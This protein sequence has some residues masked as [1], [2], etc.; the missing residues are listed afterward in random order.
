MAAAPP[1]IPLI[2]E[3]DLLAFQL[4]HFA[5]DTRPQAWF[6]DPETALHY[7]HPL[8]NDDDDDGLGFYDD[9]AKRTLT[10][11]QIAMFRHSE[12]QQVL[13]ERR[14]R[15]EEQE[16]QDRDRAPDEAGAWDAPACVPGPRASSLEADL[17]GFAHPLPAGGPATD[18]QESRPKRRDSDS[19]LE[20]DLVGL[21]GSPSR[22][23]TQRP[24]LMRSAPSSE[25]S[26]T[27]S[28]KSD[29][30][31]SAGS[32][33]KRQKNRRTEVPYDER[34]KRKWEAFID[35][36]DPVEGSMTH[37]RLVRQLDDVRGGADVE[38]DYGDDG[39]G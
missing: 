23:T 22:E 30:A 29:S 32:K 6:V 18:L 21:A 11:E 38:V 24:T 34:H 12:I 33:R 3:A 39:T 5:D 31:P 20:G 1:H 9:G 7:E 37:R 16:Y 10:D 27:Q 8:D 15:R 26:K 35:E 4:S 13:R 19:S 2:T 36:Q 25:Q 28:G 14:L 17:V